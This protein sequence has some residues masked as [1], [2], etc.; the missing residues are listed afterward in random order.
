MVRF[1]KTALLN[2]QKKFLKE[3][4]KGFND[5]EMV[6]LGKK[7]KMNDLEAFARK[8][9][10][11]KCFEEPDKIIANAIR[12]M[13]R[14]T[15]VSIFEKPKFRDVVKSL[16]GQERKEFVQ[17]IYD[18]LHGKKKAGFQAF[19]IILKEHS[20]AKWPVVTCILTYYRPKTE[21]FVK[22]TT[23]KMIIQHLELDLVYKPA[24]TWEFYS[25]LRSC[26]KEM[27]GL[28]KAELSPNNPAFFG[29]LM[30]T[31]SI[32]RKSS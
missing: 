19:V 32:E 30:M 25:S 24:P 17:A 29:F 13:S 23:V 9:F 28:C 15:M 2:A 10:S 3:Y 12:L 18:M 5:P 22:P 27:K 26:A 1:N 31:L 8:C 20:L 14:S 16:R 21:I 4:P 11:K 6:E 7:H